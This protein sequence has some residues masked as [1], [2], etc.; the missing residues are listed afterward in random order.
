MRAYERLLRYVAYPTASDEN[1][2]TCPSTPAQ[3]EL[4]RTL[5]QEM[6][7][8]GICDAAMD[9][10]GYVYGTVPGNVDKKVPVVGFIAHMDVVRD[11]PFE[12]IKARVHHHYDGGDI[13][14]NQE[15]G[16]VMRADE[17]PELKNYIGHDLVVTDGTTL[18]GA[19]DKAGVA[20]IMTMAERLLK[21]PSIRHGDIKLGFTPDE[22]IGRGANLF[23]IPRF[24]AD[25]AYT[26][27]GAAFGAVEYENFNASACA[28]SIRG[29]NIHP[30]SSKNKMK[31][32]LLIASEFSSML[33]PAE[34]PA[35]TELREG[36]YHLVSVEGVVEQAEMR[37]I[38]RDHDSARLEERKATMQKVAD[39]LND[40][41]GAGT[42]TI[43]LTDSYRNMAEAMKEHMHIVET[44]KN[45][46]RELGVEPKSDPIRGGTDGARLTYMGLICPNL[47]TGSHNHHGKLEYASVQA[48]DQSVELLVKIAETYAR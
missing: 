42:V 24:G 20:E 7:D 39:F 31:N 45:A 41:Y 37:Y 46:V 33:P 44:A 19:D 11:V 40:R 1:S 15:Q 27:D 48:M 29:K 32:A 9:Q 47:G 17:F 8:M 34:T 30:G 13:V 4:A 38:L 35:H 10:N 12:N 23:D 16:I 3:L 6:Q 2:A 14:L 26:V 5:V 22:E 28:V 21:D 18:L 25:F 43:T 36:F